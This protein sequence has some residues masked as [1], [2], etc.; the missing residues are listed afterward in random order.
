MRP[1]CHANVSRNYTCAYAVC[2]VK[3]IR[4]WLKGTPKGIPP[5]C[6][7]PYCGTYSF[8]DWR[9]RPMRAWWQAK[10]QGSDVQIVWPYSLP[11]RVQVVSTHLL[12]KVAFGSGF[13]L[14]SEIQGGGSWVAELS[15]TFWDRFVATNILVDGSTWAL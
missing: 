10:V 1:L 4:G 3:G 7:S 14:A 8:V 11:K 13:L 9:F 12:P 6:G 15:G 2:F 5:F